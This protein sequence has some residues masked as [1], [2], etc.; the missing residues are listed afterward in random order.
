MKVL[1]ELVQSILMQHFGSASFDVAHFWV[2]SS[3]SNDCYYICC[4]QD[5][6]RLSF[7]R[8]WGNEKDGYDVVVVE[9]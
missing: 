4:A 5:G 3:I 7:F 8:I 1:P 9:K 6:C 2:G